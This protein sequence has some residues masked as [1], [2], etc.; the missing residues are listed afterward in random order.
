VGW[1]LQVN[2]L[3][4]LSLSGIFTIG[5]WPLIVD[6]LIFAIVFFILFSVINHFLKRKQINPLA[7]I[8]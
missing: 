4:V 7:K 3:N 1:P 8:N 5:I 6:T 2:F